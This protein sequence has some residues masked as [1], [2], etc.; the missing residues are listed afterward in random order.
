VEWRRNFRGRGG[1]EEEG[2]G[3]RSLNCSGGD[4][5]GWGEREEAL[6]F[7]DEAQGSFYE[8]FQKA[9]R[10]FRPASHNKY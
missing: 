4:L 6:G 3:A 2:T 8:L 1:E 10:R 7:V 9:S 5:E